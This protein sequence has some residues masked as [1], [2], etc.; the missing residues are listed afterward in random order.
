[1]REGK[2]SRR[3]RRLCRGWEGGEVWTCNRQLWTH[4]RRVQLARVW[5][6][7]AL[8]QSTDGSVIAPDGSGV[9][10]GTAVLS[11]CCKVRMR[12]PLPLL[13]LTVLLLPLLRM[14]SL[15]CCCCSLLQI[16][17]WLVAEGCPASWR[18]AERDV[19]E[20]GGDWQ[21]VQW[22]RE[23]KAAAGRRGQRGRRGG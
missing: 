16:V 11:S 3:Y 5:V 13:L 15:R 10:C 22:V 12:L 18:D 8:R 2:G 4:A 23:R 9:P 14:T 21:L 19:R 17:E 7:S 20:R 1:M 6:A